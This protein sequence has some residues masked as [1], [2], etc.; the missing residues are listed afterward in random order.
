MSEAFVAP[1]E[2]RDLVSDVTGVDEP[3]ALAW[4]WAAIEFDETAFGAVTGLEFPGEDV[5]RRNLPLARTELRA[6]ILAL[7]GNSASHTMS[8]ATPI[9]PLRTIVPSA[10]PRI[11][12]IVI[13]GG[14]FARGASS[15]T[16]TARDGGSARASV[17]TRSPFSS[18]SASSDARCARV[19]ASSSKSAVAPIHEVSEKVEVVD[20]EACLSPWTIP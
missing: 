18:R 15:A 6:L 9:Q 8:D 10:M 5:K 12:A 1:K 2:D 7:Q 4:M 14:V 16:G 19:S 17:S 3:L 13:D 20:T 11:S